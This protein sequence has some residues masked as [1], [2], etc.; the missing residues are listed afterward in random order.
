MADHRVPPATTAY[1]WFFPAAVL[2]RYR[3]GEIMKFLAGIHR[4]PDRLNR[5]GLFMAPSFFIPVVGGIDRPRSPRNRAPAKTG[6]IN[7]AR[8]R[9]PRTAW[10]G[11]PGGYVRVWQFAI[12]RP[13]QTLIMAVTFLLASFVPMPFGQRHQAFSRRVE[14]TFAQY[15]VRA[16]D[17]FFDL[18]KRRA[19]GA[20]EGRGNR[21]VRL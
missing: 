11:S 12:L 19:P 5:V 3:S 6:A 8:K 2:D 13:G 7:A 20:A 9:D 15:K 21:F 10:G 16:A 14:R 17:N 18:E 1:R 4:D